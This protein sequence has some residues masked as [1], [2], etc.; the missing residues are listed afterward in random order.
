MGLLKIA[1]N[2]RR[3]TRLAPRHWSIVTASEGQ[4]QVEFVLSILFVVLLIFSIFE[5]IMMLYT[6]NVLADSAK[7]GVRYGVVHGSLSA[8]AT[9]IS[10]TETCSSS[11]L[12]PVYS[13]VCS[14][15]KASFHD[16]S[17]LSVTVTYPDGTAG[18]T[19]NPSNAAPNRVQVL[20]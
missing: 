11:S 8:S 16:V 18:S 10:G 9:H 4:A 15:A 17:G 6:Y 19:T 20:V 14:Y 2:R 5:F 1:H 3:G 13:V 7:E 12:D